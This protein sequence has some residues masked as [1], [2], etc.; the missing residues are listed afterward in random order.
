MMEH[1]FFHTSIDLK[2]PQFAQ[3]VSDNFFSLDGKFKNLI[4]LKLSFRAN[5][6]Q[7]LL[8]VAWSITFIMAHLTVRFIEN[9]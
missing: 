7:R 1:G 3:P 5:R 4:S 8:F 2:L 9:F 6:H